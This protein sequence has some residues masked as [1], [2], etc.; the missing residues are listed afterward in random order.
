MAQEVF[1]EIPAVR[2]IAKQFGVFG[3]MLANVNKVL[4]ILS[5]TLKATAFIGLV[6]GGAVAFFID[7]MRPQIKNWSEK[8]QWLKEQLNASVDAYERGDAQ[9]ATLFY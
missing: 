9:G 3:Q 8:C 5:N 4:Q 2:N 6:G 7:M 1:M